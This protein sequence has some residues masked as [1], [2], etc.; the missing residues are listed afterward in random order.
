MGCRV[1]TLD[2]TFQKGSIMPSSNALKRTQPE[3]HRQS[4]GTW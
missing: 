1:T 3:K 2:L 4:R